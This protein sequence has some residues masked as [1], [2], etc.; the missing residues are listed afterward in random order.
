MPSPTPLTTPNGIGIQLAV[1]P[2]FTRADR[3]MGQTNAQQHERSARYSDRERRANNIKISINAV[4]GT[5]CQQPC[6]NILLKQKLKTVHDERHPA[7]LW[8]F[9]R[10]K[11]C[12]LT[13]LNA[14]LVVSVKQRS[15]VCLSACP[16]FLSVCPTGTHTL[17]DLQAVF[18]KMCAKLKNRKNS[19]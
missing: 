7:L 18:E 11:T 5:V 10:I 12:L 1:L 19:R 2:Q 15:G 14:P 9:W 13:A 16:I 17:S 4:R 6:V 8:R 3:Q